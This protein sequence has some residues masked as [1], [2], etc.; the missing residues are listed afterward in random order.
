MNFLESDASRA[1]VPGRGDAVVGVRPEH[2]RL[3]GQGDGASARVELVEL[4]GSE[5]YVH[6]DSGLVARVPADVRP[7]EGAEVGVSVRPEDAHFFDLAS[8]ERIER[9]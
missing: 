2:V 1:L 6:L 9:S 8:G 4:A 3:R 5:A 7:T